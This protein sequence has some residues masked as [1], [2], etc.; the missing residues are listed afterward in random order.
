[1]STRTKVLHQNAKIQRIS[2]HLNTK[3]P[4]FKQIVFSVLLSHFSYQK[5][6]KPPSHSLLPCSSEAACYPIK[7]K[8][9]DSDLGE[10]EAIPYLTEAWDWEGHYPLFLVKGNWESF[11]EGNSGPNCGCNSSGTCKPIDLE[12]A[13]DK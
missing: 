2:K 3:V 13:Y 8:G 1:M 9:G 4:Q 6:I 12:K 11:Y 7:Q 5:T 10:L